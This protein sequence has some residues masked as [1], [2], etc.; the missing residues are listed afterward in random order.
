MGQ[1]LGCSSFLPG[2][3]W[4]HNTTTSIVHD[5]YNGTAPR[6]RKGART[7]LLLTCWEIWQEQNKCT[8][9]KKLPSSRDIIK[10]ITDS[11]KLWRLTG[12]K[13]IES[14]FGDPP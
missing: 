1:W 5:I 3:D 12:A 2:E 8:F 9:R 4:Q 11:I 10:E 7:L 13:C 14:P 6:W